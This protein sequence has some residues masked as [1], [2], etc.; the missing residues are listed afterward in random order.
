[1]LAIML[2]RRL[3]LASAA[4]VMAGQGLGAR[5]HRAREVLE[6][7]VGSSRD[8]RSSEEVARDEDFW[9]AVQSAF[10]VDRSMVNLNNGG[11][12]PSP[13]IVHEVMKRRWDQAMSEPTSHVLWSIQHPRWEVVRGRLAVRWGVDAEEVAITRNSSESLQNLQMGVDLREGD[14]VIACTQDYPRMLTA[15]RQRE[16]RDR[17]R[18][19]LVRIPTPCEDVA[20][21]VRIYEQAITPR[22][23]LMLLSHVINITG[24]ILPVREVVEMARRHGVPVIV[25]GAHALAQFEFSIAD[26]GCDNYSSSLHKWLNAPL[27]TGLLFVRRERIGDFWPLL[28][29]PEEMRWNIRKFEETG[30]RPE[31]PALGIGEALTF[32]DAIGGRRKEARLRYLRDFWVTRIIDRAGGR[33]RLH[34]S[35]RPEFS[36]AI[37]N[38]TIDGIDPAALQGWL[39]EKHRILVTAITHEEC[40]G[41]RVTP[42]IYTTIE[43]LERFCDAVVRAMK[44]GVGG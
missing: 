30:T 12:S 44:H 7:L 41:I 21:V 22:T 39:W 16:Q 32:H 17:V 8:G 31:A 24:Q 37:A 26:L 29:A 25:D 11:V 13:A 14:E 35:L 3:F 20:E 33:A 28:G 15:F 42:G 18:L 40:P 34:T 2:D 36:C 27:G 5:S 9:L 10:S 19:V 4:G 38:L 6:S 23:R 43:E 1:M